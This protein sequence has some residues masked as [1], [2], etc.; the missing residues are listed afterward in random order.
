MPEFGHS[1][2]RNLELLSGMRREPAREIEL[3][4]FAPDN[5]IC[6]EDYRHLFLGGGSFFLARRRSRLQAAASLDERATSFKASASWRPEHTFSL[7]GISRANRLAIP[8]QHIVHALIMGAIHTIGK[9]SGSL[10]NADGFLYK[11]RLSD[12][13][14]N[15]TQKQFT[16]PRWPLFSPVGICQ[17][18]WGR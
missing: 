2:S 17:R 10:S 16:C 3:S 18:V 4:L 13:A 11:I 15:T 7:S 8:Q 5:H 1:D 12:F 14:E 9:V 6:I